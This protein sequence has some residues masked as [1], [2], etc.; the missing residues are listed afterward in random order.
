MALRC[1]GTVN[2]K[3][4]ISCVPK[5]FFLEGVEQPENPPNTPGNAL[6]DALLMSRFENLAADAAKKLRRGNQFGAKD[7]EKFSLEE[8]EN[9]EGKTE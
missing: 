2:K 1:D 9:V 7:S 4:V 5:H 3:Q 6:S 8:M